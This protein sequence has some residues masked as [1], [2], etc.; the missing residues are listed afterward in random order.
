MRFTNSRDDGPSIY[1][2]MKALA[3]LPFIFTSCVWYIALYPAPTLPQVKHLV[4]WKGGIG[5][6]NINN[7]MMVPATMY[8]AF[9]LGQIANSMIT[10]SGSRDELLHEANDILNKEDF[11]L[12][13]KD[14][15]EG[16][17]EQSINDYCTRR[18]RYTKIFKGAFSFVGIL[19]KI[20][21]VGIL[22]TLW[23]TLKY[24]YTTLHLDILWEQIV[25]VAAWVAHIIEPLI[26]VL[27]YTIT[28]MVVDQSLYFES[29]NGARTQLCILAAGMALITIT[30]QIMRRDETSLD[31]TRHRHFI[32]IMFIWGI[33]YLAPLAL[34]S[35]SQLIGFFTIGCLFGSLGFVAFPMPYGWVAGFQD[36]ASIDKCMWTSLVITSFSVCA[37]ILLYPPR[38]IM[39]IFQTGLSVFGMMCFGLAGLIK[40]SRGSNDTWCTFGDVIK[41]SIFLYPFMWLIIGFIGTLTS[42]ASLTNTSITFV[43]LWM[44]QF[45][46][47]LAGFTSVSTFVFSC[48]LFYVTLQLG[49]REDF[50]KSIFRV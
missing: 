23:P 37:K 19:S 29:M 6:N 15:T 21:I 1:T 18:A 41:P 17:V 8:D 33:S 38:S 26:D 14:I 35:T 3:A 20:A 45:Y 13:I 28:L 46:W 2:V 16:R 11:N 32:T 34:I 7:Q 40:S 48:V 4:S 27:G 36:E 49:A 47:R 22:V 50:V 44:T 30:Y 5:S 39:D 31:I 24:L 12:T 10:T 25:R 9:K 42:L 43:C